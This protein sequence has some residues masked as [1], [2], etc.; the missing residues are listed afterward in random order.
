M[1]ARGAEQ[2]FF[3]RQLATLEL[4]SAVAGNSGGLY[5]DKKDKDIIDL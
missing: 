1:R 4:G 5:F 2:F 3:N